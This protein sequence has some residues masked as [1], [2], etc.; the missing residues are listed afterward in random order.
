[1]NKRWW[2]CSRKKSKFKITNK[3]LK[4]KKMIV[5]KFSVNQK[6]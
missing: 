6:I 4:F 2:K 1:M 5:E 3:W